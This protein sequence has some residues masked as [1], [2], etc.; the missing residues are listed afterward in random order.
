MIS[1]DCYYLTVDALSLFHVF[2]AINSG[3]TESTMTSFDS[4]L[5]FKVSTHLNPRTLLHAILQ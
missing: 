5:L 3:R 1:F 2:F 4:L